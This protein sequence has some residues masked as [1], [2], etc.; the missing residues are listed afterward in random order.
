MPFMGSKH[1]VDMDKAGR[2]VL[3]KPLR[4]ELQLE[5]RVSPWKSRV[6]GRNSLSAPSAGQDSA[7]QKQGVWVFRSGEPL[8]SDEVEKTLRKVREERHRHA[9]GEDE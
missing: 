8:S 2:I 1:T 7:P 3:P 5:D 9:L 6:P 4:D